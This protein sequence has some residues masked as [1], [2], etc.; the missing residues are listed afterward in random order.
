MTTTDPALDDEARQII[1]GLAY[2][3]LGT[4]DDDGTPRVSPVY[5][6]V[7]AYTDYYW[8]SHPE[9]HHSANLARTPRA[10]A[11]VLDSTSPVGRGRAVYLTGRARRVADDELADR[12]RVAFR[13]H[14]GGRAFAVEELVEGTDLALYVL[15]VEASEIHVAAGHP[16][17]GTGR[18]RRVVVRPHLTG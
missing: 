8:V 5:F 12:V 14:L 7:D 3:A 10:G 18:D 6:G 9:T 4:V 11:A 15:E 13:P 16:T 17:L 2:L 1:D